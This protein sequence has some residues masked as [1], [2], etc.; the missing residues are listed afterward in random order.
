MSISALHRGIYSTSMY[1][2]NI[3][4]VHGN[5]SERVNEYMNKKK[6]NNDW[7]WRRKKIAATKRAELTTKTTTK[8]LAA[9]RNKTKKKKLTEHITWKRRMRMNKKKKKE[10]RT[11]EAKP[12]PNNE[13]EQKRR[14]ENEK[15]STMHNRHTHTH[16][17]TR[18]IASA[19]VESKLTRTTN[20]LCVLK[21][22]NH[23]QYKKKTR[24]REN[25]NNTRAHTTL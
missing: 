5:N 4:M 19:R 6:L 10:S 25:N 13:K 24:E 22:S 17:H 9:N 16:T 8:N 15:P 2:S 20:K 11:A 12:M 21:A 14:T 7:N 1:V 23:R 3:K 18:M